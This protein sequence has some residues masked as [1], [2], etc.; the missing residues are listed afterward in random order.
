MVMGADKQ[1]I[2][3]VLLIINA[4]LVSYFGITITRQLSTNNNILVGLIN[5][6]NSS[7]SYLEDN[8]SNRIKS[9]LDDRA[10]QVEKADYQF[11]YINA[12]ESKAALD[13][14]V[15][16]KAVN[17]D[18]RIYMAY[19]E[20]DSDTVQ[21][22][23]LARKDGLTYVASVELDLQKNYRYD[24]IE[25]VEGRGQAILN[26][27]KQHI[28]LYDEFY[29]MR[30][31]VHNSG[32]ARGNE[33][34]DFD[35]MFSVNDFGLDEFGLENVIL[36]IIYEDR[37]IDKIDITDKVA[38]Y[39]DNIVGLKERYNMA[40]ASGRIDPGMSLEEFKKIIEFES[41]EKDGSR[42]YYTYTHRIQYASDY[43]ELQLDRDKAGRMRYKLVITCKDGYRFAW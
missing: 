35:F 14:T 39:S 25:R 4:V 42:T 8:I 30:V 43:P 9:E 29:T 7:I 10:N 36:E 27:R 3:I 31:Q 26:T 11:T 22:V 13:F 18:S 19:G 23:E 38:K 24:V 28:N 33:Q 5:N 12:A 17:A 1:K 2:I 21:E 32:S 20:I 40:V 34:I 41:E 16:L 15:K 6:V 37:E